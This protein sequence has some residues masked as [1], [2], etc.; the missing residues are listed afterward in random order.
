MRPGRQKAVYMDIIKEHYPHLTD[1]YQNM[2]AN[3]LPSGSPIRTFSKDLYATLD[4]LLKKYQIPQQIP[5]YI[6]QNCFTRYDEI[7]VLLNHMLQLYND[8]GVNTIPLEVAIKRYFSWLKEERKSYLR[9][10]KQPTNRLEETFVNL[11]ESNQIND[12]IGNPKLSDFI[13][14]VVLERKKFDYINLNLY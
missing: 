3:E 9:K 1:Y 6:Y 7:Y 14:K 5:H 2:Y 13:K 4:K 11:I 12:I 8:A 10:R